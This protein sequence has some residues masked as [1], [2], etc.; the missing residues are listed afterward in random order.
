MKPDTFIEVDAQ[1]LANPPTPLQA[2][3]PQKVRDPLS[4]VNALDPVIQQGQQGIVKL[5]TEE[6][7]KRDD[8]L[9]RLMDADSTNTQDVYERS[10]NQE[11][12]NIG[13]RGGA[14]II[15]Q[16]NDANTSLAALQGK[17][18]TAEAKIQDEAGTQGAKAGVFGEISRQEAVEVGNQALMVQALQGNYNTARQIA[19]DTAKFATEDRQAEL[20]QLL[21]Q[22]DA[23]SGIVSGQEAQV[24]EQ[25]KAETQAEMADLER[26]QK[27]VDAAIMSGAATP[28]EMQQLTSLNVTKEQK[29]ALAQSIVSRGAGE[30]RSMQKEE[31][32]LKRQQVQSSLATDSVQRQKLRLDMQETQAKIDQMQN[33]TGMS[34]ELTAY[35][36]QYAATGEIPTGLKDTGLT[37]SQ[38]QQAAK[39]LPKPD[40]AIVSRSTG[41]KPKLADDKID[42]LAALRDIIS[43]TE[44]LTTLNAERSK[45]VVGAGLGKVF[46]SD[47]QKEYNDLRTEIVDLLSRAR[48]GAALTKEEEKFYKDQLPGTFAE[49][50][51]GVFSSDSTKRIRDNFGAKIEGTLRA[52]L[53]A[54]N[55]AMYGFSEVK[56]G[57]ET[58]VVGEVIE[59]DTGQRGII[60]A[61]GSV[62]PL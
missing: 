4:F 29:Q 57:G 15:K 61:D 2:P 45:G 52:K 46:G 18:R 5:E 11:A 60:N 49:P 21:A 20:Q 30:D 40:G 6:A 43:K 59:N 51:F 55:I 42:G 19:L 8:I 7:Q 31:F 50:A 35:A 32:A 17:F 34:D 41:I 62:T 16:L 10:F 9:S 23:I 26:T 12:K 37:L 1:D 27:A 54:Q 58:F 38:I 3:T 48:T 14:D 28:E 39:D 36:A 47:K 25:R 56:L 22:F 13:Y 53:D 33:A 44:Q 24:L